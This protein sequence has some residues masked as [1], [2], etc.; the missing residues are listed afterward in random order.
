MKLHHG[1]NF[2]IP[3]I[4]LTLSKPDKDFGRRFYPCNLYLFQ[5]EMPCDLFLFQIEINC[6]LFLF[7]IENPYICCAKY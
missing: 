2:A 3:V 7:Q 6:G 5:I 4:D 1:S